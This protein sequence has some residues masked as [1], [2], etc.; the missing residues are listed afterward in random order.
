VSDRR[1]AERKGR[2]A[3]ILAAVFLM[4]KGY[5][6]LAWRA[7]TPRGEIDLILRH[8]RH[9]VFVEVKS[10]TQIDAGLMSVT[11]MKAQRTVDAARYWLARNARQ[12]DADYRF[13]IVVLA[14]YHWPRHIVNAYGADPFC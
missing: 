8:R 3:E 10:R 2:T 6:L 5:R 13:D 7:K 14:A 9:I 12:L 4:F 1:R 11:A